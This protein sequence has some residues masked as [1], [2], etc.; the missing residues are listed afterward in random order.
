VWKICLCRFS[1]T[2]A[3][4]RTTTRNDDVENDDVENDDVENHKPGA[5]SRPGAIRQFPFPNYFESPSFASEFG[6]HRASR[7]VEPRRLPE[8]SGTTL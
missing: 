4:Q 2:A 5:V 6:D 1:G 7:Q 8:Q 3:R